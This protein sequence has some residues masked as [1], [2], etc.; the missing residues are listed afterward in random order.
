MTPEE[1]EEECWD[2]APEDLGSRMAV[3]RD[4]MSGYDWSYL[5]DVRDGAFL[6]RLDEALGLLGMTVHAESGTPIRDGAV[7][8]CT[9]VLSIAHNG[10]AA[11]FRASAVSDDP[12]MSAVLSGR[13]V[14]A[15]A[16][17]VGPPSPMDTDG[18]WTMDRPGR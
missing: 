15:A 17:L 7:W 1:E 16:G 12:R 13:A 14:F 3:L 10:E 8:R 11:R 9:A 2:D 4:I 6:S 18:G 5:L